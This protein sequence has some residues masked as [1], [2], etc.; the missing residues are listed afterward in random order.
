MVDDHTVIG[1]TVAI[2]DVISRSDGPVPLAELTRRTCMPKSTVRR[3]ANA[4]VKHQMLISAPD[5]YLTG[6][7]LIG[8]RM[9][10]TRNVDHSLIVQPYL[11]ELHQRSRGELAWFAT[12][13]NGELMLAGA[14]FDRS[15]GPVVT[16]R[17]WP[18]FAS[19]GSSLV[20]TA[21]GRLQVAHNP[22]Q[23]ERVLSTEIRP[24]TRYSLT[25]HR[26]H[27]ALLDRTRDT[28]VATEAEQV[29]LGWSCSAAAVRDAQGAM[30]AAIGLIGRNGDTARSLAGH[31]L[32]LSEQL[33]EDLI[34]PD[35]D[36]ATH[37]SAPGLA[38][39]SYHSRIGIQSTFARSML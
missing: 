21:V 6:G 7:R 19:L 31:A 11:Q 4:L 20:L 39:P 27:E 34:E 32:K 1:R 38:W 10:A 28:G 2:L 25:D 9:R 26:K 18:T 15:F 29:L 24:L 16:R 13:E 22:E 33:A 8:H 37:P 14:V 5:G 23:A 35:P 30:V 17:C 36:N 3:I 12:V